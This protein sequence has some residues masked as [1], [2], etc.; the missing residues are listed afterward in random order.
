MHGETDIY[1]FALNLKLCLQNQ[2]TSDLQKIP[3]V[4]KAKQGM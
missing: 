2:H 4:P 1:L 3:T